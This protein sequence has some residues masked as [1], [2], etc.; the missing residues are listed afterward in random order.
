MA[1]ESILEPDSVDART[2]IYALGA[3]AYY[4]L[5]GVDVFDGKSI[6]EV[7]SQHLHQQP[8]PL[9]ARGVAI[10]AE[11]EAVVLA[12]LDKDPEPPPSERR[13][14]SPPRRS[15]RRRA[16]GQRRQPRPGGA[17]TSRI[18]ERDAVQSTGEARPSRSMECIDSAA[19]ASLPARTA[20]QLSAHARSWRAGKRVWL[21]QG[22]VGLSWQITPR[23]LTEALAAGGEEA[24]RAFDAMLHMKR[25]RRRSDRGGAARLTRHAPELRPFGAQLAS[26]PRRAMARPY[27]PR[28]Q[29][30]L[31]SG[32][33]LGSY[34]ILSALG[35]GGMGEV[36][37][38]RDVKLG[39]EVALKVLARSAAG[40][41]GYLRRFE[42]EARL[43]S[44]LN[45]PN[46][47]TIYGVGEDGD[48]AY[49]AMELVRGR[50]LRESWPGAPFASERSSIL[51]RRWR[52]RSPPHT[53]VASCTAT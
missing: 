50:T 43:A 39:R 12:C 37:R 53:P 45:H 20:R 18:S 9:S 44:V 17:S 42:E 8:E 1:P 34:E 11:L 25:D 5:A 19:S 46:I 27:N 7:C 26:Y 2:D 24:K 33:R 6:V 41:P 51:P 29:L 3:V 49:I 16:L 13:R 10:P 23:V 14:A 40:D 36:Y 31:S 4:L 22:Q 48:I 47:V 52:T 28:Q 30:A 21:V 38:A 15:V 35:A 32:T